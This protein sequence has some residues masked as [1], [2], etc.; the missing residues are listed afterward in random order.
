MNIPR[1]VLRLFLFIVGVLFQFASFF[2]SRVEQ[3][4]WTMRFISPACTRAET[5]LRKLDSGK[6]LNP[7]DKGFSD[8][9]RIVMGWLEAENP[10]EALEG[11]WIMGFEFVPGSRMNVGQTFVVEAKELRVFLSSGQDLRFNAVRLRNDLGTMRKNSI[12]YSSLSLLIAGAVIVQIPLFF[13]RPTPRKTDKHE[14][15]AKA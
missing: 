2:V 6:S 5:G 10:S 9:R 14:D 7:G 4:P 1:D 8:I 12:F 13:I 3:V 11:K 15:Q